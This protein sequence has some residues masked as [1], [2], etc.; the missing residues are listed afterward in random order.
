MRTT[1]NL[2]DKLLESARSYSN[3]K[4]KTELIHAALRSFIAKGAAERLAKLEG[5]IPDAKAPPRQRL[6][7]PPRA[8][9]RK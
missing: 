8:R 6:G 9:S 3:I 5:M 4:E 7:S 1:L 2:D